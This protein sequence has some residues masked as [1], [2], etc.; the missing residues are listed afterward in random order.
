MIYTNFS[1]IEAEVKA[2][3]PPILYKYKNWVDDYNKKVLSDSSIWFSAPS[4]L[5]DKFDVRIGVR[6]NKD[7]VNHPIFF[8]KVKKMF[9][10]NHP[11]LAPDS[12]D[13]QIMSGN[14]LDS[15]KADPI[16]WFEAVYNDLRNNGTFDVFGVFS[17]TTDPLNGR[18]WAHYG[19][20]YKGYCVG[21]DTIEK[22][23]KTEQ[24]V[25]AANP[26][27]KTINIYPSGKYH[28]PTEI[29][30]SHETQQ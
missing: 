9:R 22:A 23:T 2:K 24:W 16:K 4:Q 25:I 17:L 12:R 27:F 5:N 19:D 14:H 21:Y 6:F 28:P 1:H 7:E 13:I 15:M 20:Q 8:E 10:D 18:M 30:S 29:D 11:F 26:Q 3:F